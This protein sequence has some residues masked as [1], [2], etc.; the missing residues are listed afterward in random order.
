MGRKPS[1]RRFFPARKP[2][3]GFK[4]GMGPRVPAKSA[5]IIILSLILWPH[6]ILN[7][8]HRIHYFPL[9]S[10]GNAT[11]GA[12]PTLGSPRRGAGLR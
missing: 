2:D 7:R 9:L 12:E 10:R 5:E 4:P 6:G 8:I 11:R 1:Q 3:F